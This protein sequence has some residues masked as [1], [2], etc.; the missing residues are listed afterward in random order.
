MWRVSFVET[1]TIEEILPKLYPYLFYFPELA[2]A[3]YRQLCPCARQEWKVMQSQKT[4][5]ENY[6]V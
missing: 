5:V 4:T 2:P 6:V 3:Y 1:T